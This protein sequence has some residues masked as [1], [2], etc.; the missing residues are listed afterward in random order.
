MIAGAGM[1][2]PVPTPQAVAEAVALCLAD[3][4]RY[5]SLSDAA[6]ANA[7]RYSLERWRDCIGERLR[8]VWGPLASDVHDAAA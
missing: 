1:L 4:T 7:R 2:L 5:L 8:A 3:E 6:R